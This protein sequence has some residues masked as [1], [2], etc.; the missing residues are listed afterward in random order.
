MKPS[1]PQS[2]LHN[3]H[4]INRLAQSIF[5]VNRHAKAA[6]NPKYLYWLKKTALERLI[7]EKKAIKEGLHFSRN[8]RFSQQQSDVLIRLGDYF[9]HI[10]PTKDDF[11]TLPHLGHLESSYRNPKTTLSLTI[12]KKTLQDYIG[13]EALKQEKKLNE[14]VPWY[15]RTYTKK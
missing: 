12:A 9:F 13:P 1:Q 6:T 10:P 8:P 5:V 14:A 4:S 3:Q 15:S 2:Q 11:R 7:T